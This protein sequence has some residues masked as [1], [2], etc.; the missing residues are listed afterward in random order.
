M[1]RSHGQP[2]AEAAGQ[3]LLSWYRQ[4]QTVGLQPIDKYW[5]A[6]IPRVPGR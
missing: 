1:I 4:R 3:W 5:R 6:E 2:S